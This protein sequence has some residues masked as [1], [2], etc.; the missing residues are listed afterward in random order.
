MTLVWM[1]LPLG[2]WLL[3]NLNSQLYSNP[4]ISVS[5]R[6]SNPCCSRRASPELSARLIHLPQR[7]ALTHLDGTQSL[8]WSVGANS[9]STSQPTWSIYGELGHVKLDHPE[10]SKNHDLSMP[11]LC[12]HQ[13][14]NRAWQRSNEPACGSEA[15]HSWAVSHPKCWVSTSKY[16]SLTY[17]M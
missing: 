17:K 14:K 15:L 4:P 10:I 3:Y 8:T 1:T 16:G 11:C 2:K 7:P 13:P 12:L 9:W 6:A 5:C